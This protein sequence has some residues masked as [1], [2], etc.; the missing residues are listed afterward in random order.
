MHF[1]ITEILNFL[2][3]NYKLHS[4][5]ENNYIIENTFEIKME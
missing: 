4:E 5:V 1:I 2:N 3:S